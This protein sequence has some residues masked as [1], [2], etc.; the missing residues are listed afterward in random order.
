[1][2]AGP[3]FLSG[4]DTRI[5]PGGRTSSE[6][7]EDRRVEAKC[8]CLVDMASYKNYVLL[9]VV[10]LLLLLLLLLFEHMFSGYGAL[11]NVCNIIIIMT[12]IMIIMIMIMIMHMI[13]IMII[14]ININYY[15]DYYYYD[16]VSERGLS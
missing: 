10:V 15:Y 5:H 8:D 14:I 9:L 6:M 7:H 4:C 12:M 2:Q 1:M 13:M 11:E 3:E 16:Q